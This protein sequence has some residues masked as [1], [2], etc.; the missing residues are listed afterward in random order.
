MVINPGILKVA[1]ISPF[2]DTTRPQLRMGGAAGGIT[3]ELFFVKR[4]LVGV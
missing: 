3:H 1:V 4:R 2:D